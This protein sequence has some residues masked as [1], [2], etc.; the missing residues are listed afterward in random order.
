[1]LVSHKFSL[2][3]FL[4][5]CFFSSLNHTTEQDIFSL[6]ESFFNRRFQI[7]E[8]STFL[9]CFEFDEINQSYEF[10]L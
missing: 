7:K 1:M 4:F 10:L 6:D 9:K 3:H 2:H 5:C 8:R